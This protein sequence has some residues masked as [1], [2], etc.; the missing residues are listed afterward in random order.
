MELVE[1]QE[2]RQEELEEV[3]NYS[4]EEILE[5]LENSLTYTDIIISGYQL[6]EQFNEANSI[7]FAGICKLRLSIENAIFWIQNL[8]IQEDFDEEDCDDT[9]DN[10]QL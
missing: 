5:N 1:A 4:E 10:A 6:A 3:L 8:E 7:M 9:E 2:K